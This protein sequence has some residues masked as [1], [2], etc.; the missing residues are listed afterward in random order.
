MTDYTQLLVL[1]PEER[2]SL[3]QVQQHPWI[4]KHCVTGERKTKRSS[5]SKSSKGAGG[6]EG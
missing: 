4:V 3:D 6:Q 5:G 2:L 1:N